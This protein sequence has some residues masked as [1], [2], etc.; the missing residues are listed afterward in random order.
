MRNVMGF[1]NG[2]G[3]IKEWENGRM[4]TG[5]EMKISALFNGVK[6]KHKK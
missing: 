5:I 1:R 6:V 2:N 4:R 3:R